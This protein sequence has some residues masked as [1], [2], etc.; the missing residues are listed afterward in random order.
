MASPA[1]VA[2]AA[3]TRHAA[4]L[5]LVAG[6]LLESPAFASPETDALKEEVRRLNQRIEQLERAERKGSD[7]RTDDLQDRVED[8][9]GQVQTL[10]KPG[11]VAGALDGVTVGAA[12]VMVGQRAATG[13]TDGRAESQL[14]YRTDISVEVPGDTLGKLTGVGD[15]KLF[16]L[17]RAGQG[18]GLQR[19]NPTLTGA[20]NSTAF[21]LTH[22]DDSTA[23]LAQAWYQLG[24]PLDPGRSGRQAR[25]E[26]TFGK[27]DLFGFFD[28]NE[29]ADDET[30]A[31]LN[32]IFVHNPLLDSGGDIGADS[33]GFAPG[34]IVSYTNDLN[35]VNHWRISFGAFG[36]GSGAGYDSSFARSLAIAQA[37]YTGR[38]LLDRP[39]T[40]RVYA[41]TNGST[42]PFANEFDAS[43]ER[44]AGWGLSFDQEVARY[45]RVFARYGQSTRGQVKFNRALTLGAQM[46]GYRWGRAADRVGFAVGRLEPSDEFRAASPSL[47]ADADGNPD[48]GFAP[49]RAE[50]SVE[51]FYAWQI[52]KTFQLSPSVQWINRPGGD[53]AAQDI[54][55]VSLRAK[56]AF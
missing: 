11:K 9:E 25:V 33:Y 23:I 55:I 2:T 40:Y 42:V 15:S 27:I 56:A 39:G 16:A 46:G 5:L 20:T 22:S 13:T 41:W 53:A 24:M 32:N 6:L 19:L 18:A 47:D 3:P 45:T 43:Q 49:S 50:T 28:Q 30:E 51:L 7:A 37:E 17:F 48:F 14:S 34:A 21:F 38:V 52:N 1:R 8:L 4:A 35:S 44:H 26:F 10:N 54:S 36:A 12:L 31:F 29:V